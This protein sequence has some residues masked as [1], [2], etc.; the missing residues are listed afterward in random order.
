MPMATPVQAGPAP[1]SSPCIARQPIL[2]TDES[3]IGYELF[4]RESAESRRFSSDTEAATSATI[5][6]L[7]FV[8]LGVLCDGRLA[9]INCSQQIL[10][11]DYF[12]LLP[13]ND[14]VI[15]IQETVPASEEVIQACQ[16]FK[17]AGYSI[18]L[19]NFVPGDK[20]EALMPYARFVKVDISQVVSELS[21]PLVARY[22]SEDRR[23]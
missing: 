14:V 5:D 15:E 4:F 16:R 22:A 10:L 12:T 20:R 6:M 23:M 19:D 9:F 2:T 8:G 1:K 21:A 13:P 11:S 18:A 7:N 17:Q 3:V